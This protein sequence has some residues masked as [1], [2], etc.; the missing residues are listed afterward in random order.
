MLLLLGT[1]TAFSGEPQLFRIGTGHSYVGFSIKYLKFI[2]VE[3]RFTEINAA[4]LL[5]TSDLATASFTAVITSASINTA[6]QGRD[7]DLR[8]EDFFDVEK[9][10]LITFQ[11]K[12]VAKK[13]DQYIA[14]GSFT[15][16]GVTQDIELPFTYIGAMVDPRGNVRTVF[17]SKISINRSA[18]G[19]SGGSMTVDDE[20]KINMTILAMRQNLDSTRMI[21]RGKKSIAEEVMEIIT[22]KDIK[23][24]LARYKEVKTDH[25]DTTYDVGPN[26][27]GI[28][29]M[30]L[31]EKGKAADAL[32]LAK[33]N[34]EAYP[35]DAQS[36]SRWG[37][38]YEK[39]NQKEQARDLY[40]KA[41]EHDPF[42]AFALEMLR[43][44]E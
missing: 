20:V 16:R 9:Y 40:K 12:R 11:S 17:E 23:T 21:V 27:L 7:E 29:T 19:V 42:N 18:Y 22:K 13:G 37:Y 10:P 28:L 24:A 35:Q 36:L 38:A 31:I 41:I 8:S 34:A 30:K 3:G 6:H 33:V 5:D 15:M 2:N 4:F 44:V 39:A 14:T 43:W 26:Q 32:Q 25:P 1:T